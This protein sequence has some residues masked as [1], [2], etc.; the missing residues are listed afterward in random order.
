MKG[1]AGWVRVAC[2]VVMG[3]LA[4]AAAGP[5]RRVLPP[6]ALGWLLAGGVFYSVGAVI[7]ATDRP[8]LW[9]GR[10]GAHDLWHC[11]VLAGSACH[12]VMVAEYIA[13]AAGPA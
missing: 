3:W 11:L 9:P 5:L 8:R 13:A 2:Y 4:V 1:Q 7:F 6:A 12:F 10:F